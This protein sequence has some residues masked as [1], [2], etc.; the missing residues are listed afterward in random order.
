MDKH[1]LVTSVEKHAGLKPADAKKAVEAVM[2]AI[3]QSPEAKMIFRKVEGVS[4]APAERRTIYL[5]G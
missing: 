2:E 1:D 4:A 5:C 3:R